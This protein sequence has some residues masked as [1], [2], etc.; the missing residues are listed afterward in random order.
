MIVFSGVTIADRKFYK[1]YKNQCLEQCPPDTK[2]V[3]D[4]DG[5]HTCAI[6]E[7]CPKECN[8]D[9]ISSLDDLKKFEGCT[10]ITG[11]LRIQLSGRK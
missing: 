10:H 1:S 6:C 2:D 7:N 8:S 11:D 9:V 4:K 3:Q 5:T